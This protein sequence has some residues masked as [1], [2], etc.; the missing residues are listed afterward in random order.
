[1][2]FFGLRELRKNH[3]LYVRLEIEVDVIEL[4]SRIANSFAIDP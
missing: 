2:I 1:M 4:S 3:S